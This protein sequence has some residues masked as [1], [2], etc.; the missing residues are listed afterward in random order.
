MRGTSQWCHQLQTMEHRNLQ[1]IKQ[2]RRK[3]IRSTILGNWGISVD[4]NFKTLLGYCG[5]A[6]CY[7]SLADSSSGFILYCTYTLLNLCVMRVFGQL[8]KTSQLNKSGQLKIRKV[9]KKWLM[10]AVIHTTELSSHLGAGHFVGSKYTHS[11]LNFFQP[12]ISLL[13]KLCA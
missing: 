6:L 8:H 7:N 1:K 9:M 4:Y 10:M 2:W 3:W 5:C 11:G 13:L 12:L